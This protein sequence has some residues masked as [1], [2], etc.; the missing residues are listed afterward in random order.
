M[1]I[2]IASVSAPSRELRED[3]TSNHGR[4]V[5]GGDAECV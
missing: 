3:G 4:V 5:L 2:R 1:S